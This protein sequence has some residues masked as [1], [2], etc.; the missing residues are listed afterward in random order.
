MREAIRLALRDEMRDD[1]SVVLFG[2]DV[3]VAGGVFKVTTGLLDEFGSLRVRDTPI[4]ETAIIG[5]AIGAA[6]AGLRPI[7]EIMFAE[8]FGV[9]FD[10]V[11]TEAAKMSYFSGGRVPMPMVIRASAG[12]G[13]SFGAQHS[14]TVESWFM[15][16]PGLVVVSP[17]TPSSA[18]GLLRAAIRDDN[19]VIFLEPRALYGVK[20]EFEPGEAAL[21]PLGRASIVRAGGDLSI[22][23]LGRMVAVAVEAADLLAAEGISCEV[24][25][26]Q[27]ILPWDHDAVSA[28]LSRTGRLLTV[29]ENPLTGGWGTDI[30]SFV[31]ANCFASLRGPVVRVTCPD[32]P[33]PHSPVLERAYIPSTPDVI[34]AARDIVRSGIVRPP[35]WADW[36]ADLARRPAQRAREFLERREA[37]RDDALQQL[38]RMLEIRGV[39]DSIQDLFLE[40]LVAGTTHTCQGQEAVA[41]GLAAVTRPGDIVSCTYRGHGV[42]LALGMTPEV[43]LGEVLGRQIGCLGGR[44]GSMH[45][46]AP[47]VGLLPTFAIVGAGIPIAAGAAYGAQARGDDQIALAVFGDGATNIGAFHEALNLSAVW[48][49]PVVFVCENNLYG[50][51]SPIASTTPVADLAVRGAS[52]NIP[53]QIIDGQDLTA[54]MRALDAAAARARSGGGP[55]LIEMKTYRYVGHSRS[56]PATYRRPEELERWK[57]RDPIRLFEAKLRAEGLASEVDIAEVRRRVQDRVAVAI[58][59][60]K[61]SPPPELADMLDHVVA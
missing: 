30:A 57:A 56:D 24:I 12:A 33:V 54:V 23:A 29:E 28:S 61:A 46:F 11:V 7:V 38:D 43:V 6:A 37:L 5:A 35:R 22:V 47:E 27:T 48:R 52:Y 32:V 17:A 19:P 50:E 13:N 8:F 45:L 9:A 58:E 39:E 36:R 40:G 16:T 42:A 31:V 4:S 3:A 10:Q 41:V 44:G 21:I 49:L 14:Q 2:E 25:D 15:N 51:Y 18:Y 34:A 60:A 26:L 1:P 53:S 20:E 55:T 59:T